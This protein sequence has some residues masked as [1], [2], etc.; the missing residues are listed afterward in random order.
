MN[1]ILKILKKLGL[2]ESTILLLGNSPIIQPLMKKNINNV[3]ISK[4]TYKLS[5]LN[6]NNF[7]AREFYKSD[8][9]IRENINNTPKEQSTLRNLMVTADKMQEIREIL[10]TPVTITSGFRCEELNNLIGGAKKSYHLFG[11][12]CDFIVG[13]LDPIEIANK[14]RDS[15]I[16]C[17]QVIASY[18]WS[19]KRNDFI[20]WVHVQFRTHDNDNRGIFLVETIKSNGTKEYGNLV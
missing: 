5:D 11:S 7:K 14:L 19:S 20:R 8:T 4:M 16:S 15:K 12:A 17:D 13:D 1:L 18:K 3:S 9:A 10:K 2:I 6:R